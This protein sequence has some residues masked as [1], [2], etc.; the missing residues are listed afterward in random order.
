MEKVDVSYG[1]CSMTTACVLESIGE[2]S[3]W[4]GRRVRDESLET[5]KKWLEVCIHRDFI[6]SKGIFKKQSRRLCADLSSNE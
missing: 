1:A 5:L 4:I 2:L 6:I 3:V